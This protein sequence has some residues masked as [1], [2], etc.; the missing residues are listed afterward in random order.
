[1]EVHEEV[2]GEDE[3][4]E[5]HQEGSGERDVKKR[6]EVEGEER[7]SWEDTGKQEV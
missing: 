6:R 7:S 4:M 5:E 1:M 2:E 3:R